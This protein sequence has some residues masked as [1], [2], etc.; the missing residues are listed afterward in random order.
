[1]AARV[2]L[3]AILELEELKKD[4]AV[5][6][7]VLCSAQQLLTMHEEGKVHIQWL[8]S[9][10]VTTWVLNQRPLNPVVQLHV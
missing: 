1:M 5:T 10:G 2:T 9:V 8:M 6:R 4:T 3:T 7:S